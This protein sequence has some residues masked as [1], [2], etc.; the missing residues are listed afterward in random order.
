[1]YFEDHVRDERDPVSLT[2]WPV[3]DS[4]D[5]R[6]TCAATVTAYS[7]SIDYSGTI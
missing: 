1:V 4:I 5:D 7:C 2:A 6:L 3:A